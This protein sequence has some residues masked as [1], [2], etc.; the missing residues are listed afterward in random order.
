MFVDSYTAEFLCFVT[1]RKGDSC[2]FRTMCGYNVSVLHGC[3]AEIEVHTA[4]QK[5]DN[6]VC[7]AEGQGKHGSFFPKQLRRQCDPCRVPR[8]FCQTEVAIERK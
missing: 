6:Y 1:S 7:A 4:S 5:H 2:G 3:E 8:I